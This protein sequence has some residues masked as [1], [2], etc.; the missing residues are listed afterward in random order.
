MLIKI[1]YPIT[2]T[3]LNLRT[4]LSTYKFSCLILHFPWFVG[5]DLPFVIISDIQVT[6]SDKPCS[7]VDP[8]IYLSTARDT[9]N[10]VD[11][12]LLT[13]FSHTCMIS[14]NIRDNNTT[15]EKLNCLKTAFTLQQYYMHGGM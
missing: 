1:G 13:V 10:R 14:A 3:V 11:N 4:S 9:K 6:W 12:V 8:V 2:M 15:L 7:L 5:V